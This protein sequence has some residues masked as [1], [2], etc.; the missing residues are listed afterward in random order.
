M[1]SWHKPNDSISVVVKR[2]RYAFQTSRSA[3]NLCFSSWHIPSIINVT[4]LKSSS[5]NLWYIHIVN[6]VIFMANFLIYSGY[7]HQEDNQRIINICFLEIMLTGV[8]IRWNA[9]YCYFAIRLSIPKRSLCW[10][11]T[12]SAPILI[13]Y[14]DFMTSVNGDAILRS[15]KYSL[16]F[17]M[18]CQ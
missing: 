9:F 8:R 6:Q 2:L 18:C 11:A 3:S 14:M 17:L 5:K 16:M 10:G 13:G 4:R 12:I 7:F 15:L 1:S